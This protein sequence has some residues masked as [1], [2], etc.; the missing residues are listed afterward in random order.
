MIFS[1]FCDQKYWCFI[2]RNETEWNEL[3]E[4]GFNKI[5]PP[6]NKNFYNSLVHE[7]NKDVKIYHDTK[8]FGDGKSS[9]KILKII[10]KKL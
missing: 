4:I 5:I 7:I 8:L 1:I 2:A 10:K 6:I 9:E 3:V